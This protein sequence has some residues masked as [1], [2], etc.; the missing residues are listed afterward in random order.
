[1]RIARSG[2]KSCWSTRAW[3]KRV[4][5]LHQGH[6]IEERPALSSPRPTTLWPSS[7]DHSVY[8]A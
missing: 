8:C 7:T 1:M 4:R 6:W 5:Y 2:Y 3:R